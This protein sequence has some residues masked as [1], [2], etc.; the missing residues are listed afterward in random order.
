MAIRLGFDET[1]SYL[2]ETLGGSAELRDAGQRGVVDPGDVLV[3]RREDGKLVKTTLGKTRFEQAGMQLSVVRAARAFERSGID[4]AWTDK[5]GDGQYRMN[6]QLWSKGFGGRMRL[7][8]G[9]KP[10]EAIDDIFKNGGKYAMECA[11]ATLVILYK[12]MLDRV[13]AKD[14]DAAFEKPRLSLFRWTD[15]APAYVASKKVGD[16]PGFLPGDHTYFKNPEVDPARGEWQGEN[17]I[18]LGDGRYF[19]H[20][21]GE[22]SA[23]EIIAALN[24]NRRP[25]ATVSA[26]RDDFELRIDP[27]A[28]RKLDLNP[29]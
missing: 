7:R 27:K 21:I 2:R 28:V 14:F 24:D 16:L 10:S 18:Y 4:F 13:G 3:Y 20:G 11:T 23:D 19:G 15:E 22:G 12:A 8:A 6:E 26:H 17:V 5:P 29:D 25:G 1:R 9:V